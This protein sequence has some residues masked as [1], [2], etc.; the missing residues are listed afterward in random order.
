MT[1]G[2]SLPVNMME[3]EALPGLEQHSDTAPVRLFYSLNPPP[4]VIQ[5]LSTIQ[6]EVRKVL[7]T[8][9]DPQRAVR[10]IRP[11]QFHLTILFLGNVP[12]AE[13]ASLEM[14]ANE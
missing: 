13:I 2:S 4:D 10:W 12:P 6:S 7:E 5:R 3:S 14:T 1:S 8:G 11:T 9:F